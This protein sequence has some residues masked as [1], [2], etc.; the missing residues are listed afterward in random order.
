MNSWR[1][2]VG[3]GVWSSWSAARDRFIDLVGVAGGGV[4]LLGGCVVLAGGVGLVG[5]WV[6]RAYQCY[7]DR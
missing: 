2:W 5:L 3:L 4:N 1:C 7:V 6:V